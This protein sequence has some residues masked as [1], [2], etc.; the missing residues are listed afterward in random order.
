MAAQATPTLR[1]NHRKISHH[2]SRNHKRGLRKA[3]DLFETINCYRHELLDVEDVRS[4][5]HYITKFLEL[6]PDVL[7]AWEQK[8]LEG[9]Q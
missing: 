6:P 8:W 5:H 2:G 9:G 7:R 3:D 4:L 1:V